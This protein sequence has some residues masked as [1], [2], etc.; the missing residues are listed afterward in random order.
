MCILIS[1]RG[2]YSLVESPFRGFLNR[3]SSLSYGREF[4]NGDGGMTSLRYGRFTKWSAGAAIL[5]LAGLFIAPSSATAGCNH[6]VSS[7]TDPLVK[8]EQIDALILGRP[9]LALGSD[10]GQLPFDQPDIPRRSPCSGL[11]CSNS[12]PMPVS[13]VMPV[14]EGRDRWGTLGIVVEVD[15]TSVYRHATDEPTPAAA[16]EN[17]SIFHP[18]RV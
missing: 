4:S 9:S 11:S 17:S 1:W 16:G 3:N 12:V 15:N 13:S 6:L 10:R 2:A 8:L 18:P 14:P 5:V 7:R